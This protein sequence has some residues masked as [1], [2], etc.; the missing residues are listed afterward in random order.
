MCSWASFSR[1][2]LSVALCA[3]P[4]PHTFGASV[5][6][7]AGT[8]SAPLSA[9]DVLRVAFPAATI[10]RSTTYLT[11]SQ[12]TR[13]RELAGDPLP[14][15]IVQAFA[16]RHDTKLIATAYVDAHV[17]R[18]LGESLLVVVGADGRVLRLEVL[19]FA[20]PPEYLPN[21]A[22]YAQFKGLALG[23]GLSLKGDV[24]GVTGASLTAA[25][26]TRAVRRVLALHRVLN[27][28]KPS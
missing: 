6:A 22:W 9:D 21:G 15:R 2:A 10:R 20:E 28:P 23:P 19:S 4:T 13:A 8:V 14:S 7:R 17:V 27:E 26:T 12:A 5:A 1:F 3:A 25:A 24:R 16:I 11:E 18:T